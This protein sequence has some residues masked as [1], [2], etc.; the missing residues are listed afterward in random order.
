MQRQPRRGN[1]KVSITPL[2]LEPSQRPDVCFRPTVMEPMLRAADEGRD[3]VP[4]LQKIVARLGF[5]SFMY[6]LSTTT[7]PRRDALIYFFATLPR[8]WSLLYERQDYIEVDPRVALGM[9]HCAPVAWDQTTAL[10]I[11]PARH[12]ARLRLFLDD[13]AR[14]GIRSGVVWGLRNPDHNGVLVVLNSSDPVFG[15]QQQSAFARN[16]GD[17]LTFGTYFHE[18]F[19]RNFVN[20][21]IPSRIRG[22]SLSPRE[23]SVI[24]LVAHGLTADDI[25]LKLG[26]TTRTVRFH[27][28]SARTKMGALNR[29]EAVAIAAKA[30]LI[31]VLP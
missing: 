29:E 23:I 26:I 31:N 7:L 15:V 6:G 4:P 30:G 3:L 14:Y 13:A 22:A 19:M 27:V 9:R 1:F 25:S 12:H 17:I 21:G 20:T 18:F 24:E 8:E 28:D 16:I 5:N 2:Q 10:A 11:T